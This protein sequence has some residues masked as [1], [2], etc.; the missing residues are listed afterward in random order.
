MRTCHV[1]LNPD[2]LEVGSELNASANIEQSLDRWEE[3]QCED[4]LAPG[5]DQFLRA[6]LT[7]I[8]HTQI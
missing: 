1:L 6:C 4:P 7:I 2:L 5:W 3:C 8:P